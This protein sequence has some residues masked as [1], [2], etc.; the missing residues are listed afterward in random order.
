MKPVILALVLILGLLILTSHLAISQIKLPSGLYELDSRGDYTLKLDGKTYYTNNTPIA[1]LKNIKIMDIT[2]NRANKDVY[3][4]NMVVDADAVKKM[5]DGPDYFKRP[6][7]MGIII[8][9]KLVF[10]INWIT[11]ITTSNICISDKSKLNLEKIA[12]RLK[13][14]QGQER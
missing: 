7:Y 3:E 12:D 10:A 8:K 5:E 2:L 13:A 14:A 6:N 4:L 11:R 9:G 1:L